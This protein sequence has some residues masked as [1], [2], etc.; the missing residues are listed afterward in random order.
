MPAVTR[1]TGG[2]PVFFWGWWTRLTCTTCGASS[3]EAGIHG[4]GVD[5]GR[6]LG[7]LQGASLESHTH[8]A[9]VFRLK[10]GPEASTACMCVLPDP[11][12]FSRHPQPAAPK[13]VLATWL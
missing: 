4:R 1:E 11:I 6:A 13:P 9:S 2:L 5:S 8:D 10:Q 7:S 3:S 12:G